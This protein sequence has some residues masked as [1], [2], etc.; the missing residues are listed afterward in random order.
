MRDDDHLA[1]ITLRSKRGGTVEGERR[2]PRNLI[3]GKDEERA[4]CSSR[5]RHAECDAVAR[6]LLADGAGK[7]FDGERIGDVKDLN[8]RIREARDLEHAAGW[9]GGFE[10]IRIGDVRVRVVQ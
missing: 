5:G 9:C 4:F 6:A 8:L 7:L 1:A 2:W 3:A 10:P